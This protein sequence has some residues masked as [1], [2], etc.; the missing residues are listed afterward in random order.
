MDHISLELLTFAYFNESLS[1]CK[2]SHLTVLID[3]NCSSSLFKHIFVPCKMLVTVSQANVN[4][5]VIWIL[6]L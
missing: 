2:L 3:F 4:L 6:A 1:K 5:V